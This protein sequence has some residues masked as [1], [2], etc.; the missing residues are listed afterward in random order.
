MEKL[1]F[2]EQSFKIN[3]PETDEIAKGILLSIY[4]FQ[5]GKKIK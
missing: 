1:K 3:N 5:L 4:C 2:A